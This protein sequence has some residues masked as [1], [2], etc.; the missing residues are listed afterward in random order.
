MVLL[1]VWGKSRISYIFYIMAIVTFFCNQL[2]FF[3]VVYIFLIVPVAFIVPLNPKK[4][5]KN[6]QKHPKGCTKGVFGCFF[7]ETP[8]PKG[9]YASPA[10]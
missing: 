7:E 6:T 8:N 5:P 3:F 9:V 4:H 2:I 10:Y 1:G